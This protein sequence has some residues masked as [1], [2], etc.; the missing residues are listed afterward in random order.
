MV[1]A[2]K[3]RNRFWLRFFW[4]TIS[5]R[6]DPGK[7]TIAARLRS[8]T[9]LPIKRI[10]ARMPIGTAKGAKA[11]L[12]H[13]TQSQDQRQAASAL[14]PCGQLAFQ[15]TVCPFHVKRPRILDAYL[16]CRRRSICPESRP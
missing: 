1:S 8:D 11:V 6:S 16:A 7:L 10:A 15:S 12:H 9:T 4:R 14:E 3:L 2:V 13:L 5:R